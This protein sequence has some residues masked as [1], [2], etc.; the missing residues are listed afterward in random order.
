MP[1]ENLTVAASQRKAVPLDRL[2]LNG[3]A[4]AALDE[5]GGQYAMAV[6][7]VLALDHIQHS[8]HCNGCQH[9]FGLLNG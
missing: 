5:T 6:A 9:F 1:K 4:G 8:I 3:G 2:L 7:G